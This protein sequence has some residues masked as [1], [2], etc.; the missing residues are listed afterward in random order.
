MFSFFFMKR[1]FIFVLLLC[2]RLSLLLLHCVFHGATIS[3]MTL[4]FVD[5][6]L[7][8]PERTLPIT[9]LMLITATMTLSVE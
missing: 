9:L 5:L 3:I 6:L 4:C 8:I 2:L 1:A 7:L